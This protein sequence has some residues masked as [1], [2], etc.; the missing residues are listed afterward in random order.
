MMETT[1]ISQARAEWPPGM[2]RRTRMRRESKVAY[3]NAPSTGMSTSNS[4]SN[5]G[6]NTAAVPTPS[7]YASSPEDSFSRSNDR[8]QLQSPPGQVLNMAPNDYFNVQRVATSGFSP[9]P[10][11][12]QSF[13]DDSSWY[14]L[15]ANSYTLA[16]NPPSSPQYP[17]GNHAQS[18]RSAISR[19]STNGQDRSWTSI[20]RA[21]PTDGSDMMLDMAMSDMDFGSFGSFDMLLPTPS[22]AASDFS[23]SFAF[24][25]A[26]GTGSMQ[27]QKD[28]PDLTLSSK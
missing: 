5:T 22:T 7:N 8:F 10:V 17:G 18:P 12:H 21:S 2:A 25:P 24:P 13:Q 26:A 6:R 27:V 16:S 14:S 3:R 20:N 4:N 19:I 1:M 11:V 23:D 28:T 15:P 9:S